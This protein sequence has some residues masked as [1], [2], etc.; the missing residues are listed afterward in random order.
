MASKSGKPRFVW[1]LHDDRTRLF[2]LCGD[3]DNDE[4]VSLLGMGSMFFG[5]GGDNHVFRSWCN[6]WA[7]RRVCGAGSPR[8]KKI[9]LSRVWRVACW[10]WSDCDHGYVPERRVLGGIG[11]DY[12]GRE[13]VGDGA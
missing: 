6:D 7:L 4:E 9:G 5:R 1:S 13:H 2:V 11:E 12:R 8:A 3:G 10:Y